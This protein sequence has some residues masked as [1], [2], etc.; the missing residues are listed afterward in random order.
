MSTNSPSDLAA[1][2]GDDALTE[3]SPGDGL[4]RTRATDRSAY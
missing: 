3:I 2:T 4:H 1:D